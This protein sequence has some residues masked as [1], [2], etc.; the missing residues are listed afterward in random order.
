MIKLVFKTTIINMLRSNTQHRQHAR[1][2]G[3][4]KQ[5]NENMRKE[6]KQMPQIKN[7]NGNEE[8]L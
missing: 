3:Q 5:R 8:C 4:C 1:T 7:T 2:D 6:P